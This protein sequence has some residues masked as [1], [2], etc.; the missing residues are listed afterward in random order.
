MIENSFQ[1]HLA[2]YSVEQIKEL[3]FSLVDQYFPVMNDIERQDFI[4]KLLGKSGD[5]KLSSMVHR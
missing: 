2:G 3:I 4:L 5:D 1:K